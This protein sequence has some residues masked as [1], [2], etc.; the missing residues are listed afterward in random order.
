M[1]SITCPKHKFPQQDGLMHVHNFTV[2][3]N[4]AV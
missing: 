2:I 3:C 4:E 1:F